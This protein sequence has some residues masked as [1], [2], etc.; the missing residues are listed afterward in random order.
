MNTKYELTQETTIEWNGRKLFR[1]KSLITIE[2]VVGAGE[3]G[4]Y[5]ESES[6]LSISGDAW[7]SGNAWVSGDAR[8]YGNARVSGN[9]WVQF[10]NLTIDIYSNFQA[11]IASSLNVFPIKG[12]YYL[13][14]RVTKISEGKYK[15]WY[16][17]E[18]TYIDGRVTRV[19][20]FDP[21]TTVSCSR[22]IHASTPFYYS[23]GDT[24]IA[25]KI[26][27]EDI[28]TCQEGKVRCKAVTTIG[29]VKV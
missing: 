10:G 7:V 15:S 19:A 5:I 27:T 13:Y 20:N 24:L 9:A 14:K 1:I 29:E 6:N 25:V 16:D 3:F 17:N 21:D 11:Y 8:V 28:I 23:Q 18:T 2:G 12:I 22:G 4:G 26:K